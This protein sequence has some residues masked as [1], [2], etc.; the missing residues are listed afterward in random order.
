MQTIRYLQKIWYKDGSTHQQIIEA[1]TVEAALKLAYD[2][3]DGEIARQW[4]QGK[5]T[6]ERALC[7]EHELVELVP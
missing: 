3:L 6:V 5:V 2:A 1:N 7:A 4:E